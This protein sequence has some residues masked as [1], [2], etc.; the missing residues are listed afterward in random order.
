MP[1]ITEGDIGFGIDLDAGGDRLG[2]VVDIKVDGVSRK[3]VDVS[4]QDIAA[5]GWREF[6]ASLI[7]AGALTFN[8]IASAATRA[9]CLALVT[10][11]AVVWTITHVDGGVATC[12][13][14][15]TDYADGMPLEDR[16]TLDLKVK[17]TGEFEFA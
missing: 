17:F 10:G 9:Q 8:V 16:M 12:E 15:L 11:G 5:P 7:D 4:N 13:G 1:N 6:V 2:Q 14:F 3:A